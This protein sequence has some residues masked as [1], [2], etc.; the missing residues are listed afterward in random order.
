MQLDCSARLPMFATPCF[1]TLTHVN[2]DPAVILLGGGL[3]DACPRTFLASV[4]EATARL[5][6][7]IAPATFTLE[8]AALGNRAG[9][10]GAATLVLVP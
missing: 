3:P 5:Q 10:Y 4:R 9:M 7:T 8:L 2:S 6:W 1:Q